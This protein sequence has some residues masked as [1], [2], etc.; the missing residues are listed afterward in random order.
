MCR[1]CVPSTRGTS[2]RSSHDSLLS[3]EVTPGVLSNGCNCHPYPG[4]FSR[5]PSTI[6]AAARQVAPRHRPLDRYRH[7]HQLLKVSVSNRCGGKGVRGRLV[8]LGRCAEREVRASIFLVFLLG[9]LAR[10]RVDKHAT[11]DDELSEMCSPMF[12]L[13][14]CYRFFPSFFRRLVSPELASPRPFPK[15]LSSSSALSPL[16]HLEPFFFCSFYS[17]Y[18][19]SARAMSVH[20]RWFVIPYIRK[21]APLSIFLGYPS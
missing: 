14:G 2:T 1:C 17:I 9:Y 4:G 13:F 16:L 8:C 15:G 18:P 6:R 10:P 19:S 21:H 3:I 5:A 11:R 20:T 12:S 7:F